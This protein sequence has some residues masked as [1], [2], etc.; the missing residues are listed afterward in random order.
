MRS[1]ISVCYQYID[2][3]FGF[4]TTYKPY[5]TYQPLTQPLF[6]KYQDFR[7]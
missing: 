3:S 2:Q 4:K 1:L 5:I 7:P 6:I